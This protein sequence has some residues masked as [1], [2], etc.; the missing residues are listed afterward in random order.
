[1]TIEPQRHTK[2]L[3]LDA[4][5]ISVPLDKGSLGGEHGKTKVQ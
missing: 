4:G 5:L 1:M 2:R 3:N